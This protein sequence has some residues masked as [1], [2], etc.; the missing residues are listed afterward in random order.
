MSVCSYGTQLTWKSL[1]SWQI[2][3]DQPAVTCQVAML[4]PHRHCPHLKEALQD[5]TTSPDLVT[6]VLALWIPGAQRG[7]YDSVGEPLKE[8]S[9]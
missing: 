9:R 2:N 4:P 6:R 8:L 5:S 1:A 3:Q 7:P